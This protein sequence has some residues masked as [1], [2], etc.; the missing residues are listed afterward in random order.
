VP[1]LPQDI[2]DPA[3]LVAAERSLQLSMPTTGSKTDRATAWQLRAISS[4]R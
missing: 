1:A 2:H 4:P 3:D